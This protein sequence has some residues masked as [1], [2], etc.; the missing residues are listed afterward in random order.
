MNSKN[1]N[2]L[3]IQIVESL[4][5]EKPSNPIAFIIEYLFKQYPDQAKLAREFVG[6]QP[7]LADNATAAHSA[8]RCVLNFD[9]IHTSIILSFLNTFSAASS[10][11]IESKRNV[12][13]DKDDEDD[14][15]DDYDDDED[16]NYTS[17]DKGRRIGV[18]A[19]STDPSKIK[20]QM[21]K[22]TSIEKS[23]DVTARLLQVVSR[24]PLLRTLD[25]EQKEIIV[26]AFAGPL[27]KAAGDKI[28]VQGDIGDVFYL[29]EEGSVDVHV[30]KGN[31]E[32]KVHTYS[33][34]DAFGELALMYNAPRAATCIAATNCRLWSL[35]RIS[36][37]VIVVAAAMQKRELYQSFLQNVPVLKSLT[38]MEIMTLADSMA[39]EEYPNNG[40][41]CTQGD[42]G[43]YFYIVREGNAI[44]TQT[45][46]MGEQ[47]EVGRLA[48]GSYFGEIALLTTKPRQATVRAVG[49]L[50]V[51]CL[52]RATFTRVM[53][54][55]DELMKRNME[56]YNK[57]AASNI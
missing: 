37:K 32:N 15:E 52:D 51:L 21:S 1:I 16:D 17:K 11:A 38:E 18:S 45:D 28:I 48:P 43:N 47:R 55:L 6:S 50:K 34:G 46:A 31:H 29:L 19:E 33:P 12:T 14:D 36:F 35:D 8:P 4:L 39:E 57:F 24:S 13:A 30:K 20:A 5:I 26:R 27:N 42:A 49:K 54:P 25:S 44:C 3:F 7:Q 9:R 2:S 41:V 23:P 53:G 22:V 40:V 10:K 56:Q